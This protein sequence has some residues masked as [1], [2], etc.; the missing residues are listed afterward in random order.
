M[1]LYWR[2]LT[3]RDQKGSD[4]GLY[5]VALCNRYPPLHKEGVHVLELWS[6]RLLN[7]CLVNR[8]LDIHV[9]LYRLKN[10]QRVNHHLKYF[11]RQIRLHQCLRVVPYK[12]KQVLM[13]VNLMY[14][15]LWH[16]CYS[17][18]S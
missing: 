10:F 17:V 1:P 5:M 4:C 6:M 12:N 14:E 3:S 8:Q 16:L 9:K 15:C 13:D 18:K 2:L 11:T 7:E